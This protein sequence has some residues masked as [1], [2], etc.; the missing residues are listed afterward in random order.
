MIFDTD[1]LIFVQRGNLRASLLID[2]TEDREISVQTLLELLQ[3]ARNKEEQRI[4]RQF[5]TNFRFHILPLTENIGHR[6]TVYIEEYALSGGLRAAD[7]IIAAT[8]TE[9][10]TSLISANFKH[11]KNIKNLD[12]RIFRP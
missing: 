8:A 2:K 6:A 10:S 7:A 12:L 5:I 11:F 9:N 1:V 4:I 3:G